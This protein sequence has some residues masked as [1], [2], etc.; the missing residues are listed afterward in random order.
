LALLSAGYVFLRVHILLI[1]LARPTSV[2]RHVTS[3]VQ[4]IH[5]SPPSF[6]GYADDS[7]VLMSI[8]AAFFIPE[9]KDRSLEEIDE[10][11]M[12]GLPAWKF[13]DYVCTGVGAHHGTSS[14][15]ERLG[16]PRS[17]DEKQ[18][19]VDSNG[20]LTPTDA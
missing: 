15:D 11:F 5:P 16:T 8:F 10:M 20:S 2:S 18:L 19:H 4:G 14:G 17:N 3:G 13:A 9:T 1:P 6:G 7:N 12:V